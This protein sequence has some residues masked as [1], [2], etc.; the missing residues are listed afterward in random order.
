[1]NKK[2]FGDS[3]VNFVDRYMAAKMKYMNEGKDPVG[4]FDE[5]IITIVE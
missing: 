4:W 1:L 2:L 3:E 5:G